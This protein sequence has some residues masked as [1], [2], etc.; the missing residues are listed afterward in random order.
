M[1][2]TAR[3]ESVAATS[4]HFPHHVIEQNHAGTVEFGLDQGGH[5]ERVEL[6]QIIWKEITI[7]SLR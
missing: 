3:L 1:R 6:V 2:L 4:D 7:I 5:Q